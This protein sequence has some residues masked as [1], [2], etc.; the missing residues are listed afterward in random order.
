[1]QF[2]ALG[3]VGPVIA[4]FFAAVQAEVNS[5]DWGGAVTTVAILA[6]GLVLVIFVVPAITSALGE[7]FF[8][9]LPACLPIVLI[10][11]VIIEMLFLC[12]I[13]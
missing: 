5:I 4:E 7:M 13:L 6:V 2:C 3:V 8:Y 9:V 11:A 1:V 10:G 12:R